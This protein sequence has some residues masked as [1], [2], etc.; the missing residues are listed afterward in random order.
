MKRLLISLFI[1]STLILIASIL[2]TGQTFYISNMEPINTTAWVWQHKYHITVKEGNATVA[3][4][5]KPVLY[6]RIYKI[7][8]G[9]H[10]ITAKTDTYSQIKWMLYGPTSYTLPMVT[11]SLISAIMLLYYKIKKH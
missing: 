3:I 2:P 1:A 11:L 7:K 4:D 6:N 5:G 8:P 9:L 10:T